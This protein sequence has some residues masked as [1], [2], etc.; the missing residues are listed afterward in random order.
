MS[1]LS[2]AF[3]NLPS[4]GTFVSSMTTKA[5]EGMT[6]V[7][8]RFGQTI[9]FQKAGAVTPT[10][11]QLASPSGMVDAAGTLVGTAFGQTGLLPSTQQEQMIAQAN[12]QYSATS[13]NAAQSTYEDDRSHIITLYDDEGTSV[14]FLVM[15]ELVENRNVSYEAVAPAQFP[16]AFQ[17][18]KG[19]DSVQW[20]INAIFVARTTDEASVNLRNINTLRGWTMPYFGENTAADYEGKLGA[21][22]PVLRF[23]G[24]REGILGE[25]PVVITSLA[26]NWPRDVDYLPAYEFDTETGQ[27]IRPANIPFPAVMSVA[28]QVV[29]SF[30]TTEFNQFSLKDYRN[31]DMANAFGKK[32]KASVDANDTSFNDVESNR[33]ARYGVAAIQEAQSVA[34]GGRGFINPSIPLPATGAG[35]GRGFVNPEFVKPAI[36]ELKTASGGGG[37]FAGGGAEGYW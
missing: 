37:D 12:A 8:K 18:Y 24:L 14:E 11:A 6:S 4:V 30:S 34:G 27:P 5:S 3:S 33:L 19:T 10:F 29:E 26:W 9:P 32:I 21:P 31:G 7:V 17:K 20:S 13:Y 35:A 28:I 2:N 25:R 1:F 15:P 22:P 23:V 36:S 16:G